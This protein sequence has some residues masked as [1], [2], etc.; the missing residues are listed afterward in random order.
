MTELTGRAV[1]VYGQQEVVKD[2]I[3]ARLAQQL[4]LQ[5]EVTDV[6]PDDFTTGRPRVSYRHDGREHELQCDFIAGCDGFHGICRS[7]V[8]AGNLTE[9][10]YTYP[11]ACGAGYRRGRHGM[12]ECRVVPRLVRL[13]L[14]R[15]VVYTLALC[16]HTI[17]HSPTPAR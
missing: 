8:P 4:P 15:P 14:S 12:A 11:F 9:V 6:V 16:T 17:C 7:S 10:D 5:F 3:A 13:L 2:L 1:T